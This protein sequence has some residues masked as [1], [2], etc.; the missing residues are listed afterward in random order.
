MYA[1]ATM[2]TGLLLV[3]YPIRDGA[4]MVPVLMKYDKQLVKRNR[5]KRFTGN[6]QGGFSWMKI[7]WFLYHV[8]LLCMQEMREQSQWSF[9]WYH[10]H[11]IWACKG[12]IREARGYHKGVIRDRRKSFRQKPPVNSIHRAF[13][14]HMHRT[15]LYDHYEWS[16]SSQ[17]KW[18]LYLK[19]SYRQRHRQWWLFMF[20]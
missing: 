10:H 8:W 3:L 14:S 19:I 18:L 13:C 15:P 7:A 12:K 2:T 20:S 16:E 5:Q 9:G 11:L 4:L 6:I 1:A 17:R